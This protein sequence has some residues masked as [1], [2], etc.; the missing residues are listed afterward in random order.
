MKNII[1]LFFILLTLSFYSQN[2]RSYYIELYGTPAIINFQNLNKS[3][4]ILD[5]DNIDID[6]NK[7]YIFESGANFNLKMNNSHFGIG[8]SLKDI[9]YSYSLK[10]NQLPFSSSTS[11]VHFIK[12]RQINLKVQG[13]RFL[14]GYNILKNTKA[15]IICEYNRVYNISSIFHINSMNTSFGGSIIQNGVK[16]ESFSIDLTEKKE[17]FNNYWTP[18]INFQTNILNNLL[19]YYGA[20]L[21]FWKND[22]FYSVNIKGY[23]D[24]DEV[25]KPLHKSTIND[26]DLSFYFG[27][28]YHFNMTKKAHN[29]KEILDKKK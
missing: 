13:L 18:E 16:Q 9:E 5:N 27:L 26:K 14:Y 4:S 3:Y 22:D 24:I 29:N 7:R 21:R 10:I 11:N 8:L 1:L 23:Y 6:F 25:I 20:K 15:S 17:G 19:L 2:K 28:V 12:D